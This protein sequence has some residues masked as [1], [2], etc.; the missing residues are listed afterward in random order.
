MGKYI[1]SN[2]LKV[3]Q[4]SIEEGQSP[5]VIAS[6]VAAYLVANPPSGYTHP[7]TH[8]ASMIDENTSKRFSSD[9]EKGIWNGKQDVL[10]FTPVNTNDSRL[11]N[12]RPASD[13]SSWAKESVKP[14]YNASEVGAT[15]LSEVKSEVFSGLSKITVSPSAPNNPGIGDLWIDSS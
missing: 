13:V 7:A 4:T 15:T 6:A 9:T 11:D 1:N 2:V 3:I 10:G 14:S 12:S 5:A 8:P